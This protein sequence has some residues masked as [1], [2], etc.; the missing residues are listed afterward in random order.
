M[1]KLIKKAAKKA[2][3]WPGRKVNKPVVEPERPKPSPRAPAKAYEPWDR[4]WRKQ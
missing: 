3:E 4:L 1:A 2:A